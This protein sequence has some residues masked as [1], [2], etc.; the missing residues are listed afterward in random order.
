MKHLHN[1]TEKANLLAEIKAYAKFPF[2]VKVEVDWPA[3]ISHNGQSYYA[4][5]K[6]GVNFWSNYPT[7]EYRLAGEGRDVRVWMEVDGTITEEG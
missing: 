4:T 7:A 5:D 6:V 2:S 1:T 3:N